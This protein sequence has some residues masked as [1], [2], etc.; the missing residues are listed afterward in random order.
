MDCKSKRTRLI[1]WIQLRSVDFFSKSI[2]GDTN[3]LSGLDL[4]AFGF[5]QGLPDHFLLKPHD[6]IREQLPPTKS[7]G[8][9]FLQV[10]V[11]VLAER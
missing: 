6:K 5:F 4:V 10:F 8:C 2:A 3:K 9:Q 7:R 1:D 11:H